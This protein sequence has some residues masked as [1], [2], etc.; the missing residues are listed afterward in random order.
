MII[1]HSG[2]ASGGRTGD[3]GDISGYGTRDI[4]VLVV[5][6]FLVSGEFH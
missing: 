5:A 2:G 6:L 3:T 4:A 1:D